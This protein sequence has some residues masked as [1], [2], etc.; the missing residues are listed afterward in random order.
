MKSPLD[1][2]RAMQEFE[3]SRDAERSG[4]LES[5]P[6]SI[7]TLKHGSL[8]FAVHR[9]RDGG[10][11]RGVAGRPICVLCSR[12]GARYL[13]LETKAGRL[14]VFNVRRTWIPTHAVERVATLTVWHHSAL[15]ADC[16]AVTARRRRRRH[17]QH[18]TER[19]I[20]D[21]DSIRLDRNDDARCVFGVVT[22]PQ[23]NAG[24]SAATFNGHERA[25]IS[26]GPR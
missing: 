23:T 26:C 9:V 20:D 8:R 12:R 7:G 10:P 15:G 6:Q 2:D 25:S 17:E 22:R 14:M 16:V 21:P 18:W 19:R 5:D 24:S 4:R 1:S 11:Y 13:V 3:D